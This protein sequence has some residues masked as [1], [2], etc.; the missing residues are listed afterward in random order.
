MKHSATL[1]LLLAAIFFHTNVNA[2]SQGITLKVSDA[3]LDKVFSLIQKQTNFVFV[4]SAKQIAGA[5]KVSVDVTNEKFENVMKAV[6]AD[7]PLKWEVDKE[8]VIIKVK[9]APAVG[10]GEGKPGELTGKVT[11]EKGDPIAGATVIVEG[12]DIV[13]STNTDG[14]FIIKGLEKDATIKVSSIGYEPKVVKLSPEL[15]DLAIKLTVSS[16]QLIEVT[17]LN[18]GYQNLPKDRMAGAFSAISGDRLNERVAKDVLSKLEGRVSGVTFNKD[19]QGNTQMRVRGESTLFANPNPLIVV[20]NFPYDG[21]IDNINPNDVESITV[22]KDA[23]AASI[24]G[25]QAG[26]GVIVI[27][28]KKGRVNQAVQIS[29][30]ANYTIQ[31]RPDVFY[32]PRI[33]TSDFIDLEKFF[34]DKNVFTRFLFNPNKPAVSPVVETLVKLK[35]NSISKS[36]ADQELNALRNLDVRDDFYRHLYQKGIQQQYQ[37]NISGGGVKNGYYFSVGYDKDRTND[38]GQ[39]VDRITISGHNNYQFSKRLEAK[40]GMFYVQSNSRN[41]SA[42]SKIPNLYPYMKLVD[43]SG[44]S[45]SVPQHRKVFEDT[46][47]NRGFLD[48]KFIPLE[49]RKHKQDKNIAS[50]IR[51]NPSLRF[52]ITK[53]ISIEASY[54]YTREESSSSSLAGNKSYAIR[55]RL[56]TFAILDGNKNYIGSN[57]PIGSELRRNSSMLVVH[58]ARIQSDF[59]RKWENHE[60]IA[61]VGFEVKENKTNSNSSTFYGFNEK[62]GAFT[63]PDVINMYSKYPSGAIDR[64]LATSDK[65]GLA[66]SENISRFRSFYINAAYSYLDKYTI[67]VSGRRDGS[68]YFGVKANQKSVPLW[69]AGV[70]WDINKEIF[71]KWNS[72]SS[73]SLRATFGYNG[74]LAQNIAAITTFQY[75]DLSSYTF[76]PYAVIDNIPNQNLKWEK[77]AQFNLGLDFCYKNNKLYGSL[78]FYHKKGNDL[79]G[80]ALIDPTV[81][82]DVVRGNFAGMK[83]NG[84]ELLLNWIAIN[85]KNL[86]F[87]TS[88]IF[89]YTA[90]KI[91]KYNVPLNSPTGLVG[92]IAGVPIV[93]KPIYSIY[94]YKWGGLDPVNGEPLVYLGDTLSRASNVNSNLIKQDDL[95][96]SGR[97]SPPITGSIN[98]DL[99]WKGVSFGFSIL[100]KL[101]YYFRRSSISYSNLTNTTDWENFHSDYSRRWQKPGDEKFTN[102]PS[103]IYPFPGGMRDAFYLGSTALIEKADHVR[104]QYIRVGYQL[105]KFTYKVLPFS[106]ANIFL[107]VNNIGIIYRA[108]NDKS[109]DPDYPYAGYPAQRTYSIGM[110]FN[111]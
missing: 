95:E 110:Q 111:F 108:N 105:N 41:N 18:T 22:L 53:D 48:W 4:Y 23:A 84:V 82:V 35:D 85:Q 16:Q 3:T 72:I 44:N 73:I 17:V 2:Y 104:L 27:V 65:M 55:N 70:K 64:M 83:S 80:D 96:Y 49:D 10:M 74:N 31:D 69:S 76:L 47:V 50:N 36:Q 103:F 78:D 87:K 19:P 93:G 33:S 94:S 106:S 57:F 58:N 15:S 39:M 90:E 45:L 13:T 7:Q 92:N 28:T 100:Y 20:D 30:N 60:V 32:K 71:Y 43:E 8:F 81:G 91:T 38:I 68:N 24:W 75:V 29:A 42:S 26:N 59:K 77:M 63:I 21:S 51:L 11:N 34:F 56:N 109:L 67:S 62:T 12:K 52:L 61:I 46:I 66:Y 89:N 97:Y 102:V 107:Y 98:G 88:L 1:L 86:K 99:S 37:I 40:I 25:V 5:K 101:K 14:T 54:Q 79:I 6:M 9:G